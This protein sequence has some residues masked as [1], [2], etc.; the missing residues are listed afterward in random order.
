MNR[1]PAPIGGSALLLSA[2]CASRPGKRVPVIGI[3]GVRP[4]GGPSDEGG[5]GGATPEEKTVFYLAS[6]PSVA[7]DARGLQPDPAD[8]AAAAPAHP[9]VAA[10]PARRL[11]GKVTGLPGCDR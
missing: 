9:G 3:D 4:D 6:G 5:Q 1:L 11:D 8:V 7:R 10:D 2:A